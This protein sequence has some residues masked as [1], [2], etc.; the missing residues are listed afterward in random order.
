MSDE[1]KGYS[2]GYAA[3]SKRLKAEKIIAYDRG[4]KDGKKK[5]IENLDSVIVSRLNN[6]KINGMETSTCCVCKVDFAMPKGRQE[7]FCPNGHSLTF[8][9]NKPKSKD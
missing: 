5:F 2:R 1:A 4:L 7:A 3:G 6:Q 9:H 8:P